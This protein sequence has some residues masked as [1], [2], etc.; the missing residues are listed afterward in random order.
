MSITYSGGLVLD[1][2][3]VLSKAGLFAHSNTYI[4][5]NQLKTSIKWSVKFWRKMKLLKRVLINIR[6]KLKCF[7][8]KNITEITL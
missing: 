6:T 8:K 5:V 3:G 7:E 2:L 4:G 1:V